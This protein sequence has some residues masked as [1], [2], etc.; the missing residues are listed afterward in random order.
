MYAWCNYL[1]M[2]RLL[3]SFS[4]VFL[5]LRSLVCSADI[6][7]GA[8]VGTTG[9]NINA[10]YYWKNFLG[11]RGEYDFMPSSITNIADRALKNVNRVVYSKTKF[12]S[13]GLDVSVR[14]LFGS[15]HIDVGFRD[16]RY[17]SNVVAVERVHSSWG[18]V[19]VYGDITFKIAKGV[20]P[21]FGTGWSF[22]PFLGF[23]INLNVG[24]VYTGKW[25]ASDVDIRYD[26]GSLTEAQIA[27]VSSEISS[28][29]DDV[30]KAK[31]EINDKI[32]SAACLYPVINL[33]LGWEFDII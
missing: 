1:I 20:R 15:W 29:V 13:Y 14:P 25:K 9:I 2:R 21:Y 12:N 8:G 4:L 33:G 19:S 5:S 18:D 10:A 28:A 23:N 24:I 3:F 11:L 26:Y 17:L 22:N 31:N 27:A 7:V 32:P 6:Y 30:K 16:M